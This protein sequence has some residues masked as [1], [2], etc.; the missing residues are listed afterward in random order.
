MGDKISDEGSVGIFKVEKFIWRSTKEQTE[1]LSKQKGALVHTNHTCMTPNNLLKMFQKYKKEWY[2][3]LM[4]YINGGNLE[5]EYTKMP[6]GRLR[7]L[8][9]WFMLQA[10]RWSWSCLLNGLISVHL[11]LF[12]NI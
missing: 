3:P 4:N 9:N 12:M 2:E 7:M 1:E 10:N 11:K 8:H 6:P 5:T